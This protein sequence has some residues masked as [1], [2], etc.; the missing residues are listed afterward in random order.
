MKIVSIQ[1]VTINQHLSIIEQVSL[2]DV[3]YKWA[4]S[5]VQRLNESFPLEYKEDGFA[6]LE[7]ISGTEFV[8]PGNL[9]CQYITL[10]TENQ[11]VIGILDED[12]QLKHGILSLDEILETTES[13]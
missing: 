2:K 7:V 8:V 10:T 4:G 9:I 11:I 13:V 3:L 5:T 1:D 6:R 12:D